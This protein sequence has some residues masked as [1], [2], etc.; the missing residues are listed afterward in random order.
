[1]AFSSPERT[2][3]ATLE[4][5]VMLCSNCR[6][7]SAHWLRSRRIIAVTLSLAS[8]APRCICTSRSSTRPCHW[9]SWASASCLRTSACCARSLPIS[10]SSFA[11]RSSVVIHL[12][13]APFE[14]QARGEGPPLHQR[15]LTSE[16]EGTLK[17]AAPGQHHG[18]PSA[19][20]A[21]AVLLD[22]WLCSSRCVGHHLHCRHAGRA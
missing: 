20:P 10:A 14:R 11:M 5:V 4:A 21:R 7:A 9:S 19:L 2:V 16:N 15:P 6:R 18:P 22:I 3:S 8:I 13:S 17:L 1:M 12:A